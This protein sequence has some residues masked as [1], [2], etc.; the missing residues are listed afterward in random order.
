M[1]V[2]GQAPSTEKM[3]QQLRDYL[4][5]MEMARQARALRNRD[6]TKK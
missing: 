5:E 2:G 3:A 4:K 6:K 1:N